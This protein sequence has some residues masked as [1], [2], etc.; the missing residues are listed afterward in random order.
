MA[1]TLP[2]KGL[3]GSREDS[4]RASQSMYADV[5]CFT[6]FRKPSEKA[7][8]KLWAKGDLPTQ[9]ILPRRRVV[10]FNTMGLMEVIFNRPVDILRKLFDGNTLRSQ[11]EEFF[12]RFGAGEAAAMCLM[13]A[14][15]LL[16]AEDSLISNSVSKKVAEA[17]E[18][19][20]LVGMPQIAGTTA[21][22]N[23]RTQAG[24]FSM[25]QV[26][27]EAEPLFSGANEGL[28]LCSSRLLYPIWDYGDSKTGCSWPIVKRI[29]YS[30]NMCAAPNIMR[31][32][33]RK[34]ISERMKLLQDLVPE[35]SKFLS[36]K[37]A[38]VNP[39]LGFDIE[40]IISKQMLLSQDW[41]LAFYGVEPGSSGLTGP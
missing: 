39:E 13:I 22:S 5:E 15:K 21:L 18:D 8:I 38:T 14:A 23:T 16:Y 33:G 29:V 35:C 32:L 19:P 36:M 17:F 27:Q 12:N 10:V 7:C 41:H 11:I 1:A 2:R 24:G 34:K 30:N 6:G 26:V 37:L 20:G 4:F 3:T 25:G 9:H 40:Q 28:C 31:I